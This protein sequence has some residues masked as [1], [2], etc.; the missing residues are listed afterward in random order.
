MIFLA[1]AASRKQQ[2]TKNFIFY[3]QMGKAWHFILKT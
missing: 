2:L 1:T 3:I